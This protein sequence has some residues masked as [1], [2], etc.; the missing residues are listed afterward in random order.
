VS[1]FPAPYE[2]FAAASQRHFDAVT[3]G[4]AEGVG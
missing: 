4:F 1:P 2:G 3:G